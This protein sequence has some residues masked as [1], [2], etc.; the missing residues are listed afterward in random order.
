MK[1]VSD[2]VIDLQAGSTEIIVGKKFVDIG[3]LSWKSEPNGS[4]CLTLNEI[5]EQLKTQNVIYVWVE[6]GLSGVI[7]QCN[8]YGDGKWYVHGTT[9]GYA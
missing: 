8:N 5:F 9:K 3:D 6:M 1:E 2:T 4:E 7:Y